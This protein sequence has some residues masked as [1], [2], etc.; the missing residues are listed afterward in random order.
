MSHLHIITRSVESLL[1]IIND[2]LDYSKITSSEL[3]LEQIPFN[4]ERLLEDVQQLLKTTTEARGISLQFSYPD[5]A[6][7]YFVGDPT[8]LRQIVLNLVGNA[9]KFTEQGLVR[10]TPQI[11]TGSEVDTVVL[12]IE[13]TGV[14][15]PEERLEAIFDQ[16]EQADNSTTRQY[17][18][19]GLGLAISRRLARLMGGD[20]QAR[21]V[22]GSG[23]VFT[24][25]LNLTETSAPAP[26]PVPAPEALPNFGLR[27]LLAEDNKFNQTVVVNLMRRIGIEVEIAENGAQALEMLESKSYDLVFMDIRMP[28]MNGYE[29]AQAIRSRTDHL[30]RIPIIALTAEATRADVRKSKESG[31]DVHLTKPI[32][33]AEVVEALDS[34]PS[35]CPQP[36]SDLPGPLHRPQFCLFRLL[37]ASILGTDQTLDHAQVPVVQLQCRFH[38]DAGDGH[39]FLVSHRTDHVL[40]PVHGPVGVAAALAVAHQFLDGHFTL[41]LLHHQIDQP[42]VE[43]VL[44]GEGFATGHQPARGRQIGATNQEA[45]GSHTGD[46]IEEDLGQSELGVPLGNDHVAGDGRLEPSAQRIALDQRYGGH[47]EIEVHRIGVQHVDAGRRIAQ[48]PLRVAAYNQGGEKVQVAAEIEHSRHG[49][50]QHQILHALLTVTTAVVT[51]GANQFLKEAEFG[52]Q[53][54]VEARATLGLHPV[55]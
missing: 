40:D 11:K 42:Q 6:P 30:A 34:L 24:V 39:Q 53:I 17:G 29:A 10:V 9:I 45:V 5:E 15:I 46:E 32:R 25:R 22:V 16:F 33:V 14:G 26:K 43:H 38:P 47:R 48:Q 19:T 52:Q 41:P 28:I 27:A 2:I 12:E 8:R 13:D 4:L 51:G 21:S 31:M 20:I 44:G 54:Q 37:Q 36:P 49:A 23:S 18:G 7:R 50:S 3:V 55:P 35:R 1:N